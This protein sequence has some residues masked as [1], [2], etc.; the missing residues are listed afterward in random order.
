MNFNKEIVFARNPLPYDHRD[1]RLLDYITPSMMKKAEQ[2]T[3][4]NWQV[5]HILDQ[6]ATGHCVGFAWAGFGISLPVFNNW[7]NDMGDKIYYQAK[8]FD[9]ETGE[10]NGSNTRSGVKAFMKFS[11]LQNNAYAFATSFNSIVTWL[12]TSGPVVTGTN[13]YD[14]MMSPDSNGLVKAKG[15]VLGGHE[16]MINGIDTTTRLL[17]CTN[18][19]GADF[20]VNGQF[21]I[22]FE[23]Y[24]KLLDESGDAVVATEVSPSS[25]FPS[26]SPSPSFPPVL[27]S[28]PDLKPGCLPLANVSYKLYK[29]FSGRK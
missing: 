28:I 7:G 22:S 21:Y 24:Q 19:W 27:P 11:K 8:I 20:A 14:N 25:V 5:D 23:D 26:V 4:M 9:G 3:Q 17:R 29:F 13:W 6:G 12:L 15:K 2:I 10:E 18:S 16:W 1:Y